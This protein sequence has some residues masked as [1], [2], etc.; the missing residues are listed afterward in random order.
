MESA[1]SGARRAAAPLDLA[2]S[3]SMSADQVDG[4]RERSIAL[5]T[6]KVVVVAAAEAVIGIEAAEETS[7]KAEETTRIVEAEVVAAIIMEVEEAIKAVDEA[8]VLV[9][10]AVLAMDEAIR[11][12]VKAECPIRAS[13]SSTFRSSQSKSW[14]ISFFGAQVCGAGAGWSMTALITRRV[15]TCSKLWQRFLALLR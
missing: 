6:T 9:A 15:A 13:L 3:T 5:A 4:A 12:V 8:A 14:V 2:A 11:A 7:N 10:K 1:T